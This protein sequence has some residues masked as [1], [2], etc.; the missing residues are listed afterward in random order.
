[1]PAN[2]AR[3]LVA[4]W[5]VRSRDRSRLRVLFLIC[6]VSGFSEL[7][8]DGWAVVGTEESASTSAQRF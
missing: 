2:G 4:P 6:A 5:L 8:Y 1:M 3:T 7:P